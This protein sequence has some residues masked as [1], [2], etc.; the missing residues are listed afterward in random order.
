MRIDT[1]W[2][3]AISFLS[4]SV[5]KCVGASDQHQGRWR[6]TAQL[7]ICCLWWLWTCAENSGS[8][9]G[10][11][12]HT[13]YCPR[14][15]L[16]SYGAILSFSS[17]QPIMFRNEVRLNVEEKKTRA[18]RERE[19]RNGDERRD[20]RRGAGGSRSFVPSGM[21]R[22]RDG[23]G[24]PPRGGMAPKMGAGSGRG[25]GI[26]G[27]GRFTTQR[28]WEVL[29]LHC[30]SST[31]FF[32]FNRSLKEKNFSCID[33]T[34]FW[35]CSLFPLCFGMWHSLSTV[36]EIDQTNKQITSFAYCELSLLSRF[37]KNSQT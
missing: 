17:S 8:Q 15:S 19:T 36:C 4:L 29:R 21:M 14:Y 2:N 16:V 33:I 13:H 6:E 7:W 28:R 37:L 24:P 23:R 26:Q 3:D 34:W 32:I 1:R 27:E 35:F 20:M 30:G 11:N 10:G 22:D 25:S 18:M 31:V 9:G 5:R 12:V